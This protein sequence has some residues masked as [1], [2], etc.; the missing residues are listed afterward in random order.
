[1]SST[2]VPV[3]PAPSIP[4]ETT[5]ANSPV[6]KPAKTDDLQNIEKDVEKYPLAVQELKNELGKLH[7]VNDLRYQFIIQLDTYYLNAFNTL[8]KSGWENFI[9]N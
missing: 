5:T 8:P 4:V 3:S 6:P 7:Y 1:M 2:P 9:E